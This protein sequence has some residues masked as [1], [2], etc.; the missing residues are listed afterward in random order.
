[1]PFLQFIEHPQIPRILVTKNKKQKKNKI[2][3]V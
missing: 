2:A 3:V 1:M